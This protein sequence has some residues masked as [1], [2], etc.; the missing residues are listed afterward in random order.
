MPRHRRTRARVISAAGLAVG[1]HAIVV[2][3]LVAS[4]FFARV[5]AGRDLLLVAGEPR[6]SK[7]SE[8]PLEIES[9]V[10]DVDRPEQPTEQEKDKKK[11]EEAT[12]IEGQVVDIARPAIEQAPEQTRF[13][14]EYDSQV[15]REQKGPAGRE[16]AG[17]SQ[18]TTPVP[19]QAP[20]RA[21]RTQIGVG[22][23]ARPGPLAMRTPE[24]AR[25]EHQFKELG[26][27]GTLAGPARPQT[28]SLLPG[29]GASSSAR[30]SLLATP[31]VLQR[32]IGRGAGSPDYLGNLDESDST[33]VNAK[34][35][36]YASFF[37]RVKRAVGDEWHPD[38]V[39]LR[40]D[41]SG[42][43]YG[44]KD[45]MT[46]LRVQL[47]ADGRLHGLSIVQASGV[48]FL[49]DE[50]M[51]AFKRAQPFPNPPP[52]LVEGD[53][54]ITFKFGFIFELGGK[55]SFKYWRYNNQGDD[56]KE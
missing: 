31:D 6:Q 38:T 54:L 50:A 18:P 24:Q 48:A 40:H 34:K 12:K 8:E 2:V 22:A 49:D 5:Q 4:G 51:S 55:T 44:V 43:I 7:E 32:A 28:P 1:V 36:K 37:N 10:Q 56:A 39:F 13:L 35:W 42:N 9:L 23:G 14:A 11:Q 53:G 17:S 47:K 27:D 45:R 21:Q 46:V 20:Q 26:P 33:A 29:G 3:L 16:Q 41:P 15:Q 52:P 30:P 25:E 19:P